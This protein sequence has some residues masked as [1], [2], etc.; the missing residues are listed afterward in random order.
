MFTLLSIVGSAIISTII[1]MIAYG[2]IAI[3]AF[4]AIDY[5]INS[6]RTRKGT[7]AV[8]AEMKELVKA[9]KESGARMSF[10]Q[11]EA[12]ENA[13]QDTSHIIAEYDERTDELLKVELVKE[14]EERFNRAVRSA[15]GVIVLQD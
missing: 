8:A 4:L 10:D 9:A 5:L 6:F 13:V 1:S 11:L 12:F 2:I 14:S 15:G 3:I 7:V